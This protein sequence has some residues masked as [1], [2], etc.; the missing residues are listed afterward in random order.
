MMKSREKWNR[1]GTQ[2][3]TYK[4]KIR[5]QTKKNRKKTNT[6]ELGGIVTSQNLPLSHRTERGRDQEVRG[7]R[8]QVS[9]EKVME[10]RQRTEREA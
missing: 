2:E 9:M 1:K 3:N 4:S 5:R 6:R 8:S 10:V 7:S